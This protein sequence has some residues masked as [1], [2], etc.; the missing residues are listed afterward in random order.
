VANRFV[1]SFRLGLVELSKNCFAV[2]A[3][4]QLKLESLPLCLSLMDVIS[5][6]VTLFGLVYFLLLILMTWF[7]HR[8]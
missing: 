2:H 8:V 3:A 5:G 6:K 1:D 7:H 4:V